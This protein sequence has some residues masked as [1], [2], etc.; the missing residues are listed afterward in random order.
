V[1]VFAG[2]GS[3][4][5]TG[6]ATYYSAAVAQDQLQQSQEGADRQARSQ[7]ERVNFWITKEIG[8]SVLHI[9]NRSPDPVG[10][11]FFEYAVLANLKGPAP[12]GGYARLIVGVLPPCSDTTYVATS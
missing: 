8:K 7:A 2:I 6:L 12:S 10:G 4:I 3:L 11:A 1:G 9:V 5:F